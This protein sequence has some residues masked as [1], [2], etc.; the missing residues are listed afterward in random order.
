MPSALARRLAV[1]PPGIDPALWRFAGECTGFF[2]RLMAYM[3]ALALTA[4]V[5]VIV[6][7]DLQLQ[8]TAIAAKSGWSA[9]VQAYPAFAV[10]QSDS[11]AKTEA[12]AIFQHPGGG[13]KD[14]LRWA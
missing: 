6:W 10:S 9:A 4:I 14:V 5:V 7:D 12:Y 1:H 11:I 3:G 13:R 2:S 8:D